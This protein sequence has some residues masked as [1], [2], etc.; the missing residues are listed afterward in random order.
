[1]KLLRF[2][3]AAGASAFAMPGGA[4]PSSAS[5]TPS[6]WDITTVK[7]VNGLRSGSGNTSRPKRILGETFLVNGALGSSG[8]IEVGD[9]AIAAVRPPSF[10]ADLLLGAALVFGAQRS[11]VDRNIQQIVASNFEAYWD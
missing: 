10:E 7:I 6:A 2:A 9:F 4:T 1:M 5:A 11:P 3:L 8:Q